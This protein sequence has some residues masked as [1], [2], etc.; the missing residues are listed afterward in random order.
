VIERR[1]ATTIALRPHSAD[2]F[3][4]TGGLGLVTFRRGAGKVIAL[5]VTQ[6]RVWDLRFER[7]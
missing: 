6:D 1:P 4:A 3:Q 5:S 2:R 7:R